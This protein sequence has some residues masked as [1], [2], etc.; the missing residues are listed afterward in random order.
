MDP[1]VPREIK[2]PGRARRLR[3]KFLTRLANYSAFRHG[4]DILLIPYENV[5]RGEHSPG[6]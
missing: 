4:I 3:E 6:I 5:P 2:L 1:I